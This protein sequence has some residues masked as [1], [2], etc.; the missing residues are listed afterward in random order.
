M[1][2]CNVHV[3]PVYFYVH[4]FQLFGGYLVN[5]NSIFVGIRWLQWVSLFKY[6]FNVSPSVVLTTHWALFNRPLAKDKIT[7]FPKVCMYMYMYQQAMQRQASQNKYCIK[8]FNNIMSSQF[9][10]DSFY[11]PNLQTMAVN[12]LKGLEFFQNGTS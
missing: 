8:L 2:G 5:L 10:I 12:E 1:H 9:I 3:C 4:N 11:F 6:S 7:T